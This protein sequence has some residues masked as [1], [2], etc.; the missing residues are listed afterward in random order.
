MSLVMTLESGCA[1]RL[2]RKTKVKQT[3]VA[4]VYIP[5]P[6]IPPSCNAILSE[7]IAVGEGKTAYESC[8]YKHFHVRR[9]SAGEC[10]KRGKEYSCL[11]RASPTHYITQTTIQRS[12]GACR[13]E[14]TVRA[15]A[16]CK[17]R[18]TRIHTLFQARQLDET[19]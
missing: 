15:S 17:R 18:T 16:N 2:Y 12:E 5:P 7:Q 4:V 14:V 6:P 3:H 19:F 8:C 9:Q 1:I 13:K 10:T 11:V